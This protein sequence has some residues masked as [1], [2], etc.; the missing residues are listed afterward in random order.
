MGMEWISGS[1]AYAWIF[2]RRGCAIEIRWIA[3][4]FSEIEDLELRRLD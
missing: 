2:A 1:R 3:G 4:H